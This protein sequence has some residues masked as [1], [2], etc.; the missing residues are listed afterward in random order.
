ME[1]KKHTAAPSPTMKTFKSPTA[2]SHPT[3]QSPPVVR[4]ILQRRLSDSYVTTQRA[5][6]SPKTTM[7]PARKKPPREPKFD[8]D[9]SLFGQP[10]QK[11]SRLKTD[12]SPIPSSVDLS[13][14][15]VLHCHVVHCDGI[16]RTESD[17]Q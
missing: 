2:T 5:L 12:E 17:C 7:I 11:F 13:W 3:S 8:L 9:L 16:K 4:H 15:E 1:A 14:A 10:E 6:Q